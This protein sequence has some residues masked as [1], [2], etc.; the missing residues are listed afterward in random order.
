[1]HHNFNNTQY[2]YKNTILNQKMHCK[3]KNTLQTQKYNYSK[4]IYIQELL[5]ANSC[6]NGVNILASHKCGTS[7][8]Y[9]SLSV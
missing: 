9:H 6:W 4:S 5:T 2:D 8:M 3:S 1:M 7:V